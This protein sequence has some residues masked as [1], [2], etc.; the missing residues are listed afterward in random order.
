[1][2]PKTKIKKKK[3]V[4]YK[5]RPRDD[6]TYYY[7]LDDWSSWADS[8]WGD[9]IEEDLARYVSGN[10]FRTATQ[11]TRALNS[12]KR[13][14][15]RVAIAREESVRRFYRSEVARAHQRSEETTNWELNDDEDEY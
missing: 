5:W 3:K 11:A 13:M 7:I 8:T 9:T 4:V 2:P 10:C 1:M 6:D 15:Q 12:I 14:F